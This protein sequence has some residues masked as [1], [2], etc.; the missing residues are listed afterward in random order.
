[1]FVKSSMKVLYRLLSIITLLSL[2]AGAQLPQPP[3]R[4]L[5]RLIYLVP[6]DQ[7]ID[8]GSLP[9]IGQGWDERIRNL[10]VK[11]QRLYK[12]EMKGHGFVDANGEGKTFLLEKDDEGD[13]VVHKINGKYTVQEYQNSYALYNVDQELFFDTKAPFRGEKDHIYLIFIETDK[14]SLQAKTIGHVC[15]IGMALHHQSPPPPYT[16]TPPTGL[17]G[18]AKVPLNEA[19]ITDDR[20]FDNYDTVIQHEL[21][22]AFGL[23]HDYRNDEYIMSYGSVLAGTWHDYGTKL[24]KCAA[25][26]LNH[27]RAFNDAQ[28]DLNSDT[29]FLNNAKTLGVIDRDGVGSVQ[30]IRHDVTRVGDVSLVDCHSSNSRTTQNIVATFDPT[31]FSATINGQNINITMSS[32]IRLQ[33]IDKYGNITRLDTTLDDLLALKAVVLSPKGG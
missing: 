7:D 23:Q 19:C 9:I 20:I 28:G 15:G 3:D 26:W 22:H 32:D 25:E 29:T 2:S 11:T 6:T 12:K 16:H 24:S 13:I 1:M 30:L 4:P 21:G 17:F 18:I 31:S 8:R 27:H 33:A 5:V 14:D 10:A